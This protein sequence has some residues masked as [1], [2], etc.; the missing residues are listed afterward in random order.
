[1]LVRERMDVSLSES[2]SVPLSRGSGC[3]KSDQHSMSLWLAEKLLEDHLRKLHQPSWTLT[4]FSY[5]LERTTRLRLTW[6]FA[7]FEISPRGQD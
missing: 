4:C 7:S 3:R 2:H 6:H 1:M 5:S